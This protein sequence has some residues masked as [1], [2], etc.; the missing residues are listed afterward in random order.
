MTYTAECPKCFNEFPVTG[1]EAAEAGLQ[2][3][4]CEHE[5]TPE[6]IHRHAENDFPPEAP[7]REPSS[8]LDKRVQPAKRNQSDRLGEIASSVEM[9]A[10]ITAAIG[11]LVGCAAGLSRISDG[12]WGTGIWWAVALLPIAVMLYLFAQLLYIRA[13]LDKIARK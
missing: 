10:G 2:C 11:V 4:W 12:Q 6:K 3:P 13:A 5:F 7:E 1:P 8:G 9:A